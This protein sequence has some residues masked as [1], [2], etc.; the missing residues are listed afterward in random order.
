V[1]AES[2]APTVVR[3]LSPDSPVPQ[4]GAGGTGARTGGEEQTFTLMLRNVNLLYLGVSVLIL[5]DRSYL[6]RFWTQ[7]EAWLAMQDVGPSGLVSA[8]HTSLHSRC[9]IVCV[10]GAPEA[11][12]S[13]LIEEWSDCTAEKAYE[14]LSS[15]DVRVTNQSDKDDQLP[16]ILA[17]DGRVSAVAQRLRI[18]PPASPGV[19]KSR[20]MRPS[21]EP[22]RELAEEA[23]AVKRV[24]TA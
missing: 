18:C 3:S 15:A 5:T 10:H 11:L 1:P 16:K 2:A 13:S 21:R 24:L 20:R 6:S 9:T 8:R 14:K 4:N 22:T 17:L 7:F 19:M 12:V 23:V